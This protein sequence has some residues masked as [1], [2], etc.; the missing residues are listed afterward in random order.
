MQIVF[1][2]LRAVIIE[3]CFLLIIKFPY[4]FPDIFSLFSWG[5]FV[6]TRNAKR[7]V[8]CDSW[9]ASVSINIEFQRYPIYFLGLQLSL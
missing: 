6:Q 1:G 3:E 8:T 9:N 5:L 2:Y 7:E 4:L